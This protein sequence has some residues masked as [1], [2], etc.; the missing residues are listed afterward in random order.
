MHQIGGDEEQ[1]RNHIS[2]KRN[3]WLMLTNH[4]FSDQHFLS[5]GKWHKCLQSWIHHR[6][7]RGCPDFITVGLNVVVVAQ[8]KPGIISH[9]K[10]ECSRICA[11]HKVY[12]HP[13]R[14]RL[15]CSIFDEGYI[16]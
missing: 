8:I 3:R 2:L 10:Q 14:P 9:V 11:A 12:L 7:G 16:T 13:H 4:V 5:N 6:L 1:L 15:S